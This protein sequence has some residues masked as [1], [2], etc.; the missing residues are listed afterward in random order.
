MSISKK[1][2]EHCIMNVVLNIINIHAPQYFLEHLKFKHVGAPV[3]YRVIQNPQTQ[4]Q[5]VHLTIGDKTVA[6]PFRFD[7]YPRDKITKEDVEK[8]QLTPGVNFLMEKLTDEYYPQ[9]E[10]AKWV[11]IISKDD[12]RGYVESLVK[13]LN[14]ICNPELFHR[15]LRFR[16]G[17]KMVISIEEGEQAIFAHFDYL[18]TKCSLAIAPLIKISDITEEQSKQW[19]SPETQAVEIITLRCY[20]LFQRSLNN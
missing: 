6:I 16:D 11:E 3:E 12:L 8:N 14:N 19:F 15:E 18:G 10:D 1:D 5:D 13:N 2:F 4:T 17:P 9:F 7:G 20:N